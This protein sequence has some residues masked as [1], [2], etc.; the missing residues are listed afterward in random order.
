MTQKRLLLVALFI[1]LI[2]N[3]VYGGIELRS[4][5]MRTSDGIPNNS[6][7]YMYQDSKGF[8]WLATLNGLSRYDGNSFLTFRPESG[9]KVSLADNRIYDLT[10]DKNGFLWI[11]TTPELFSCYDLQ[12]ACF[13]DYTGTGA[14]EQNY[15]AVFIAAN[16]DV[17]LRHSANGCR[18]I[19]HQEDRKMVST[20]FKTERGNLPDNRVQFINEDA[21]GRIWIGTQRGLVSVSDGQYK[22]ED[23]LLHFTS[24][25]AFKDNMYFLT[26]DGDVYC[27]Q[28][29]SQK[30]TKVA[31]LS[32]IAGKTA[33]TGNFLLKNKW[34]ILTNTGVYNYDLNLHRI[35][36]DADLN[37]KNGE[38]IRDNHGD[39]W[40]YNHTG[41]V[42]YI[43]A[44][45]GAKKEFQ[46][47]PEDK[48]G[49]IDYERYHMVHDSRGIIWISTYGNG[50]FAYD[51][52]E[53]KLE[54][55]LA[56]INDQSHISSD[57]LLYVMEDRAGGIWVSS[58]YSG[59]SRISVL[60]EGTSRIYPES[61]ELFDRSNTIR[62]LTKMPDGD[63]WV[64][65][66]KGG[67]YTFDSNLH[68][69]MTNQYFHSNIYAIAEDNRG[70]MWVG[71]RGNGLKIG[72]EWYRNDI[73][74][75]ASLADN[76]V[77]SLYKDRKDRMW[78]GTFG[79]GLELAE[80]MQDGRYNFRHF[81]QQ[82]FGLRM[83]RVIEEDDNGMIWV[84]TSEG[85]CIFHPD[86]L[87]ANSDDYHLFNYTNGTFCSNEIRCIYRDTKGRMWVGTSGSGL[88]LCEPQD[89]YR[90]LKYEHYGTSEG[91]VNDVIQS[92]LGDNNGNL[93]VATEY[94]ISK[95]N[96]NNHSFENYFF[97]S[98]T[99]GNVYSENSAC[100]GVDGKLLFGTNYGLLVI[101]P[102]KI[103]DSETFSPVV[104]T[105]LHVNGTQVNPTMED[106][107]LKQ[108]LAYSDKIT[109]KY[110]QNSFLI[111]FSTFDY[112]DS[113]RTKYMY[114]LE[115]YDKGWSTPSP[116]NFASFKYLNPGTYILHVKSCNGAGVW[117]ESETTLKIVIVPPFWKTNWAMLGYV[118]LLIVT[119]YFAFRIVRNF[120]GLR[121]RINVEKQLTEYKLVF[122]TN[123]SHEFRTP[124][125]LI[126]GALE[127]I[128]RVSDI[129]R[130]LIHPLKTMDKSTQRMLRLINQLLEFRK[131][132]NNKLALSLEET[133]VIAFLYEIFLSFGDVAE[134]K[135]MNFRFI[136]SIPSYK[137]FLDKGN[138]D[139]VTYNLLSNAFKYTPS[140]GTIIL[141]V[142]VDE[143]NKMLQIQVSDTGVG[144]PKEKQ[145]E[146]FKRFMQ[147]SFSG[148]SIGVGLH[149]SH[150]LVQVHKGTIEYKDN[151]GGGSV[152]TVCIPTDKTIYSEKDFLIPG[153]V[154]LK[155]AGGQAHHLLEL[156]EEL[157]EPE[158]I[159]EPLNKRKVLI[160]EDDNDIR[161]FLKEEVGVYFEVEVAA[162]GTAGF[163]KARTYDADLIICDVLMPGMTGFEVTKKLK[164]DFATSHIPIILLTALNSPEKHLE[165]IESGADAYIAK[166]FSIKLLLA[167]VFRL[168]EQRD[169][170][171][172]KFSSEPGIVRAAVCSTDRDKEF[173]DRL[174]AVLE[175]NLS[176]PEFSID[177]FAQ[178]MKLGRT[179]FYRKLRGVTGYSPNEYLRVVRMK[180]AAELLLSGENLTVAEVSY[181]VGISD[182]FYFS[183][184]FKTQFGVAPSVYQRGEMKEQGDNEAAEER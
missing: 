159:A 56:N 171:R 161:E 94:G 137:M 107:P 27:H 73:S 119:L 13:V 2:F 173:A 28:A 176:R 181:K 104:F 84:G 134:Q 158:K 138:L 116:L 154:L 6:V 34:V 167:R 8:L 74:N 76:N 87:I 83:I 132:Q 169:K 86:S 58:E 5:Q 121:N 63:I 50:L 175:Q 91:L 31:A 24:S 183:K 88:N 62:M 124:L 78:I 99:L 89:N 52:T 113:G 47:I 114:W 49:Y 103:Q 140:N 55:F 157:P 67:L 54:H 11:S 65:T 25:L 179:V 166:P 53:D 80:P 144:I 42:T 139:K 120:N 57:F 118:L 10:E 1:T 29:A 12:R 143:V 117:N 106:S 170:L 23:R 151:E 38:V 172:E 142:T 123:I 85:V 93:W 77:F 30:I 4:K 147:S 128:Q 7:R 100:V 105:D 37:V 19:V 9:E 3:T 36:V 98:Y 110:F 15:S 70:K 40:I 115:N 145:N 129:P 18:R 149:L 153:N 20:E 82:K 126:Q 96:P 22:V 150:E 160:I 168:I 51:T 164:S 125:T 136:P 68:S 44:K 16:G 130:D 174:A 32:T 95:F 46:L 45:N 90:S 146:L 17:W 26:A 97:S 101:D 21:G 33:P 79:G 182:P 75:P 165:G 41:H 177:E 111:D 148:D 156:S 69:K 178:L 61:R 43:L 163:E 72:E 108:S 92:I 14:L 112:S 109:L 180:K 59:L 81:L 122:F 152:F 102:D 184:C 71:T 48:L 39:F 133:D 135:N 155:E 127:K 64:G 60:N 131:M 162:D 141:S 66:R 35:S